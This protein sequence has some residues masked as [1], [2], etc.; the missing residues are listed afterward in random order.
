MAAALVAAPSAAGAQT[1]PG[2]T[3]F[4]WNQQTMTYGSFSTIPTVYWADAYLYWM[5]SVPGAYIGNAP[6]GVIGT[7]GALP[8]MMYLMFPTQ[9]P[10]AIFTVYYPH[11]VTTPTSGGGTVT[12]PP[13][14]DEGEEDDE[15]GGGNSGGGGNPGGGGGDEGGDDGGIPG[16]GGGNTGGDDGDDGGNDDGCTWAC[17]GDDGGGGEVTV[18]PE[19]ITLLLLGTG[20]AGMGGAG[21]ARRRRKGSPPR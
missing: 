3:V 19:P 9:Y 5:Y 10:T 4:T 20:L 12:A 18:T 8:Y 15:G 1:L 6:A 14:D 2:T 16:G 11:L 7:V 13:D 17:D 21:L